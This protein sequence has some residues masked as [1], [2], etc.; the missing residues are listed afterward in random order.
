[1]QAT[2]TRRLLKYLAGWILFFG[3]AGGIYLAYRWAEPSPRDLHPLYPSNGPQVSIRLEN[4]PFTA[5]ADGHKAW[6][7]WAKSVEMEHGIGSAFVN[8][9]GATLTDIR[10]GVLY[11]SSPNAEPLTIIPPVGSAKPGSPKPPAPTPPEALGPPVA[12]FH[13]KQGRYFPGTAQPLPPDL[14]GQFYP[15]WQF[16]LTGDV[17]LTT[18]AGDHL[19]S[20]ALTIMELINRQT[21]KTERRMVCDSGA[22]ITLNSIQIHANQARYDPEARLVTCFGGVRATYKEGNLQTEQA[23]WSLKDQMIQCPMPSAGVIQ[24]MPYQAASLTLDL[25]HRIHKAND[26]HLKLRRDESGEPSLPR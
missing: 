24:K 9:Q 3:L 10:D 6:S 26:I 16:R 17:D 22:Q 2:Q 15:L 25:K 13:A 21:R 11:P 20:D 8:L 1:M 12:R 7:L 18:S 19:Q 4:V 5:Y 23:T 14:N